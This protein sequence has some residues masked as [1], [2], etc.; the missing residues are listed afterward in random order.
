M[1]AIDKKINDNYE[2]RLLLQMHDE[3]IYEIPENYKQHFVETLK[4]A[5]EKTVNLKVPLPVKVKSGYSWGTLKEVKL[6]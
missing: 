3:L 1:C 2:P 5:M 4:E 6:L